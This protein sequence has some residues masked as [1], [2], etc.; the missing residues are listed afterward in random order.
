MGEWLT[1]FNGRL[2]GGQPWIILQDCEA[3]HIPQTY[4]D[5]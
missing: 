5:L 1:Y 4:F 3:A 2:R